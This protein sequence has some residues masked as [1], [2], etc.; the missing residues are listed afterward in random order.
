MFTLE[1][2]ECIAACTE[3]PCLQVNY[4]YR[5][6]VTNAD[7][8]QLVDDLAAGRLDDE[9]PPHGTLARVRQKVR[10]RPV[11]R[12]RQRR[13]G[14]GGCPVS[15][16]DGPTGQI[17]VPGMVPTGPAIVTSRFDVADGYT[18]DGYVRTGGYAALR[19]ALTE[20]EPGQVHNEVK[21]GRAARPGRRRLP[22]PA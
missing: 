11:G 1:D 21:D 12:H 22:L 13:P 17:L 16:V 15:D 8:D 3:A 5:Y 7:F 18:Y 6:K 9:I 14:R 20:M 10:R 19:K 4:R 2:V